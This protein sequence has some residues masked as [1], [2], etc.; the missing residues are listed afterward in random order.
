MHEILRMK[1]HVNQ[2]TGGLLHWQLSIFFDFL[3]QTFGKVGL[4]LSFR[5]GGGSGI[6]KWRD[7]QRDKVCTVAGHRTKLRPQLAFW[8][9]W[10]FCALRYGLAPSNMPIIFRSF[11]PSLAGTGFKTWA[12]ITLDDGQCPKY[13]LAYCNVQSSD[14]WIMNR[15]VDEL[16]T[17]T[18]NEHPVIA[19]CTIMTY[20]QNIVKRNSSNS[21]IKNTP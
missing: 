15:R 13:W 17:R 2:E 11:S 12:V 8:L 21:F 7:R 3:Y 18:V 4:I 10:L 9:L 1:W 19:T 5:G 16:A 6:L 14:L 20:K